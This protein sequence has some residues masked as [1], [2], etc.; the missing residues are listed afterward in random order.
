MGSGGKFLKIQLISHGMTH[1]NVAKNKSKPSTKSFYF[2]DQSNSFNSRQIGRYPPTLI[3]LN[4][5]KK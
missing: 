4:L 1:N 3:I 5:Y 2:I